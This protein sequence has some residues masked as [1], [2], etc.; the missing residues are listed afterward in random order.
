M[1]LV[2]LQAVA[3]GKKCCFTSYHLIRRTPQQVEFS[4]L[5]VVQLTLF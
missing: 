1:K 5:K 3:G 4:F 2:N